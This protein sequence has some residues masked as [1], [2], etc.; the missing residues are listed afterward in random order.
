MA[1]MI[2]RGLTVHSVGELP[3]VGS[4]LPPFRLTGV[5]LTEFGPGIAAGRRLVLTIFP[6]VDTG[7]CAMSV[8]RF[9][10]LAAG[11]VDTLVLC[12]SADLPMAQGRFCGAEGITNVVTGS[13][14]RSTF[15]SD[16]GVTLVDGPMRGLLSR[17]IVVADRDG[18]ILHT[19]QAPNI[20]AEPDYDAAL[21]GLG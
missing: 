3:P 6:S 14:F 19:E 15:G 20:S 18:T 10:E 1:T 16:Y 13:S 5:D 11:L 7:V 8:R 9:N 2:H 17:A 21:A 4:A 12:V